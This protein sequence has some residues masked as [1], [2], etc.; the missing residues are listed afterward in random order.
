MT[1]KQTS[2]VSDVIEDAVDEIEATSAF[3]P[4]DH[5]DSDSSIDHSYIIQEEEVAEEVDIDDADDDSI[6]ANTAKE[7][8]QNDSEH[9]ESPVK[10]KLPL[11]ASIGCGV[12]LIAV[13][14]A[15]L[16]PKL[17]GANDNE[18]P[19]NVKTATE[20][21]AVVSTPPVATDP[22]VSAAALA[23][24]PP[25]TADP[26][27]STMTTAPLDAQPPATGAAVVG[28]PAGT[29]DST[30]TKTGMSP[31]GMPPVGTT[32][33]AQS[34]P[35]S[36]IPATSVAATTAVAATPAVAATTKAAT[37]AT[38]TTATPEGVVVFKTPSCEASFD[39]A[40]NGDTKCGY[41]IYKQTK[42][43]KSSIAAQAKSKLKAKTKTKVKVI[44][45]KKAKE[46]VT[47]RLASYSLYAAKGGRIWLSQSGSETDGTGVKSYVVGDILP[48]G[49]KIISITQPDGNSRST[50]VKT[51][52]GWISN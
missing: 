21:Q 2:N 8:T 41:T 32:P 18:S 20:Q 10:S 51:T 34:A 17:F 26:V 45:K 36:A 1:N 12:A 14:G 47:K 42:S 3:Q 22:A 35:T 5:S 25:V 16:A 52:Q 6:G 33:V 24:I 11:Y 39:A 37:T 7:S 43:P 4:L 49:A 40:K 48:N 38:T 28:S 9:V 44:A 19:V 15:L 50:K 23:G 27:P 46:P 31:V 29:T 30:G 13:A